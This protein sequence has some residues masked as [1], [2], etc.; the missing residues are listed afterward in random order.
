MSSS[1]GASP[2]PAALCALSVVCFTFF[3]LLTGRVPHEAAPGLIAICFAG[4]VIQIIAA[5]MDLNH[6][7]LVGGT[8]FFVFGGFFMLG[9]G[10]NQTL[11]F[12]AAMT[13][14]H[15]SPA[16]DGWFF[17]CLALILIVLTP[18]FATISSIFFL[19]LLFADAAVL[20][21]SLVNLKMIGPAFAPLAGWL[22]LGIG[23]IGIYLVFAQVFNTAMG[24]MIFP[25]GSPLIKKHVPQQGGLKADI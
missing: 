8:T 17:L 19:A 11:H 12:V 20:I 6:G 5:I 2:G 13:K 24:K 23:L 4:A 10:I 18:S 3:A 22:I 15:F 7:D 25:L 9:T 16:M 1:Q 14:T 21:L